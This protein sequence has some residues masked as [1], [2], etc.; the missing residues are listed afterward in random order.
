MTGGMISHGT[1]ETM[2]IDA[3]RQEGRGKSGRGQP[4]MTQYIEHVGLYTPS[5]H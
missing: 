3:N 1:R 2:T 5:M 4:A